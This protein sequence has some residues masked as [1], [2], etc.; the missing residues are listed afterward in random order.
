[1]DG[2]KC[3]IQ[4]NFFT[5]DCILLE[6]ANGIWKVLAVPAIIAFV[7]GAWAL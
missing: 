4:I 5:S 1:M 3:I 6:M 7:F 2:Y